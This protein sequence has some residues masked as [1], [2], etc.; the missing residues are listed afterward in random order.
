MILSTLNMMIIWGVLFVV[1]L[2]IEALTLGLTTIW[3]AGGALVALLL[4]F[5]GIGFTIQVVVFLAV[6]IV[7][8][9]FTRKLFVGKLKTGKEKTNTDAV[10]GREGTAL[11]DISF[12]KPGEVRVW[13]QVWTAVTPKDGI[14]IPKDSEVK[15]IDIK[16]VKAIVEP[17]KPKKPEEIKKEM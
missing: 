6:S 12:L 16:G 17:K 7:L 8:L 4:A 10:I 15:V 14:F 1:F 11:T 5:L 2:I 3:F 13:G 9:L